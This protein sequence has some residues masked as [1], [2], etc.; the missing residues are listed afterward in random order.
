[1]TPNQPINLKQASNDMLS[2]TIHVEGQ[3]L[4]ISETDTPAEKAKRRV[5]M[6]DR[7]TEPQSNRI[8]PS[9]SK[10]K[11][12]KNVE[13]FKRLENDVLNL[14]QKPAGSARRMTMP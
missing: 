12:P 10:L 8:A 1:M 13:H 6:A 3:V 7:G 2:S 11:I 14:N 5:S 9:P 4:G